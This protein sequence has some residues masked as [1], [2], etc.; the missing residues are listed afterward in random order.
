MMLTKIAWRNLWRNKRRTIIVLSSLVVGA[1]VLLVNLA[2]GEGMVKQML[3][4]QIKYHTSHIQLHRNGFNDDK[5]I[6][7]YVP[8]GGD[9]ENII[10]E[11]RGIKAY[12]KRTIVFGLLSSASSSSGVAIVGVE[13]DK[14]AEITKI[15]E[16]IIE[17]SY[18]SDKPNDIVI[19]WKLAEKLDVEIGSKVVAFAVDLNGTKSQVLFRV[20]GI[21]R[22]SSSNF[23]RT[24]VYIP[25]S[26]AQQFLALDS[27]YSEIAMILDDAEQSE[28]IKSK[29]IENIAE[30]GLNPKQYEVMTYQELLPLVMMYIE[31][32]DQMIIYFYVIIGV[33]VL[34]GIINTMLMSVFERIQEFG[35][36]MSIGMSKT[37]IFFM[38]IAEAFMLGVAGSVIG[39]GLGLIINAILMKTGIDFSFYSESLLSIGLETVIYPVFSL[40]DAFYSF[41][42]MPI[43]T[44]VGA[45]YPAIKAIRL[46]PTDA[47]RYV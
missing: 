6:Q 45:I 23:D 41:L 12:S 27:H 1:I 5:Q 34:F 29:I 36:L 2:F 24:Y 8:S 10:A 9:I 44:V 26:K 15:K 46:K 18:F 38:V 37:R 28:A 43:A 47:M 7:E 42:T 35:V 4:N 33:A 22:S 13:P 32:Y 39:I 40:K 3:K 25:I 20:T 31:I 16:N 19:G 11:T 14:E 21:Y 30:A 17:G